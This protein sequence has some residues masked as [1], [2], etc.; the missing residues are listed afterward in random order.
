MN[1]KHFQAWKTD[2]HIDLERMKHDNIRKKYFESEDKCHV[3]KGKYED[4]GQTWGYN[5][6]VEREGTRDSANN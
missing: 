1:I 4:S 3:I 5:D 2:R 6:Y